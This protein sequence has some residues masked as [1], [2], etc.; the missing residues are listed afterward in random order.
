MF[1]T[2]RNA[3]LLLGF[4]VARALAEDT[5]ATNEAFRPLAKEYCITCHNAQKTEGEI[6]LEALLAKPEMLWDNGKLLDTLHDA[7]ADG[8]MPPKKAKK[9]LGAAE[10][11]QLRRLLDRAVVSL[12]ER[13][14]DDPGVVVMPRLT[15]T[16]YRNVIRDLSGGIVTKAGDYLPN[17]GG[18]GEGFA[19]VGEAQSMSAAQFEKYLEAAKGAL[20]HLRVSPHDGLVWSTVPREAVDE[21]KAVI[22]EAT[23]DIIAWHIGQQQKWGALHRAE[24]EKKFGSAHALYLEA[25]WCAAHG[26]SA[27]TEKLA[28]IALEKW[29]RILNAPSPISPFAD[30]AKAWRAIPENVSDAQLRATCLAIVSGKADAAAAA[31]AENKGDFAPP[32][33]ISF[34][35]AKDEV[36][37]AARDEGRWPF[38]IDIGDA[39]ELFLIMT[40]AGNGGGGEYGLWHKGRFVFK[41]GSAKPWQDAVKIVG[42]NSGRDFPWGLD[43]TG[44]PKLEP[45]AVGQKPP[46]ALKFAVPQ[47]AIV[48]EVDFTL[49]KNRTKTASVQALVLKEMPASQSFVPGRFVFGGRDAVAKAAK[50]NTKTDP[51]KERNNLLRKRNVAEANETKL[52]LNAE[53]NIF[54]DWKR[55]SLE[56]IRGPWPEHTAEKADPN[57]PYF[58]T[59]AEVSRNATP[60]DLAQLRL[61]ED[62]L[63]ALAQPPAP[64]ALEAKA[65]G[66]LDA[67]A[68]K[69]WRRQ[70]NGDEQSKL[71]RLYRDA[72]AQGVSFDSA[73]KVP[74]L[75]VLASRAFLFRGREA[76]TFVVCANNPKAPLPQSSHALASRLSF[77]LWASIPDDEILRLAAADK[78]RDP[79]VLAAQAKRILKDPRAASLATD[80]AA[81]LLGFG[82]FENF[83]GP[84]EKRF[85]EFT[86]SLRQ[87]MF[88]EVTTFLADLIR[89]D[90]PLTALLDADYTFANAELAKHYG[91]KWEDNQTRR[92][93]DK[94][95]APLSP[96]PLLK[97]SLSS[98]RGG[99][100]TM[101]LFLTKT[102]LPLRTSPVQRGVWVVEQFLGR[103]IPAPPPNVPKISEDEK[104]AD[105]L[106]IRDQLAKHRADANCAAC[107]AR[108]DAM[109][110]A[111]EN[112]DPIGRWRTTDR[113]GDAIVS[114]DTLH[115]GTALNGI[116]GLK[117]YLRDHQD[118]VFRH[119][120]RKLLGYALGRA[121]LPGDRALL[122]RMN[123]SLAQD[124]YKFSTLVEAIVSSP[125]FT[126]RRTE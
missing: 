32:Y 79:A 16:E 116:T 99:L 83:T 51:N 75:A 40:D 30:W 49:D 9:K 82:D 104:S 119:F 109:G 7:I 90:R 35:E 118:E 3:G 65:C 78:L 29:T 69:A 36:L 111:L 114:T 44:A 42:A 31:I 55:T 87:A 96:S 86:P 112:F 27:L 10:R 41:D 76:D 46:G 19:N 6:D 105:G 53:R 122:D 64:G 60:D 52:G 74:L 89:N 71:M 73:M 50:G 107:H 34:R 84:D 115:D 54:A 17:E 81:Q 108:F 121:V 24:L 58:Y 8:D 12:A 88:D 21:P 120:T 125:Q 85:A 25:A 26:R 20:N 37:T 117:K 103:K 95:T 93:G 13:Q 18:A 62:R 106:P 70:L 28:P 94:E 33:E 43:G 11:E 126:K 23:D 68:T 45:D 59:V 5:I 77:F 91:V 2:F 66:I 113:S 124:G 98:E 63:V 38:R 80:F 92:P 14:R 123:T 110:V 47:N 1:T 100:P 39:K 61:L 72:A 48:F 67:F 57:A 56:A 4:S 101:A 97:V 15:R 22:K 102:S